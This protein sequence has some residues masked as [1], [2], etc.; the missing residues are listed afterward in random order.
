MVRPIDPKEWRYV[1]LDS[2]SDA[3][4]ALGQIRDLERGLNHHCLK[5]DG[6]DIVQLEMELSEDGPGADYVPNFVAGKGDGA[7]RIAPDFPIDLICLAE[8]GKSKNLDLISD[9]N[10]IPTN[11]SWFQTN[12]VAA[13]GLVSGSSMQLSEH[14]LPQVAIRINRAE[15][16]LINMAN[17]VPRPGRRL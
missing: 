3:N 15:D 6:I 9:Q 1:D 16:S 10:R 12:Y 14:G 5:T 11:E 17:Y 4:L 7:E 13:A 8:G 2:M